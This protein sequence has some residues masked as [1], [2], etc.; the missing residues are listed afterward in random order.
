MRRS[1]TNSSTECRR[2]HD[3]PIGCDCGRKTSEGGVGEL[4]AHHRRSMESRSDMPVAMRRVFRPVRR[5][6]S[7]LRWGPDRLPARH[8]EPV[9]QDPAG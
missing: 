2:G 3:H 9:V 1:R 5:L 7:V 6:P 8:L 4:F